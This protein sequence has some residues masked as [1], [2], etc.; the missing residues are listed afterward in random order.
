M[1][2]T[3]A[4]TV[5]TVFTLFVLPLNMDDVLEQKYSHHRKKQRTLL[6]ILKT[7]AFFSQTCVSVR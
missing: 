3:I 2:I 5:I 7:P 6:F 4:M 1:T